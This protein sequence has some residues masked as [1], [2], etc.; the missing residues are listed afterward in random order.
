MMKKTMILFLLFSLFL[1]FRS[2][3]ASV[4]LMVR[5]EG[6]VDGFVGESIGS[7]IVELTLSTRGYRFEVED[8][9][10]ITDWFENIPEGLEA[11]V[12]G[13]DD[14]GI[15]V[16]FE[17]T[18][19]AELSDQIMVNVPDGYIIDLNSDDSIG[20]LHNTPDDDARY[21]IKVRQPSAVYDSPSIIT[22]HVG[23]ELEPQN[24]YIRLH[25]TTCEASM[26]GHEFEICNGMTGRVIEVRP[27]NVIVVEY[28]GVPEKEDDSLIHTILP[29][30]DLKCDCDLI[31]P[32]QKDVRYDIS[33]RAVGDEEDPVI[34]VRVSEVPVTGIE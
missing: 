3:D 22:G 7:K 16:S 32:D 31:V 28:T 2:I 6:I 30:E 1:L 15:R 5:A 12:N 4:L 24:V 17:G 11:Y 25:D 33:L 29:D 26:T 20:D 23:E 21:E 9:E 14:T 18:P 10:E 34:E 19:S 13:H 8:H 27:D